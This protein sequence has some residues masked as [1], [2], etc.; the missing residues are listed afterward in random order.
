M[1][2]AVE[3][4]HELI[5]ARVRPG[6]A[7]IDATAGNGHDT[8]FLAKLTGPEGM[9]F[10]FDVQAGA[11]AGTLQ[12]LDTHGIPRHCRQVFHAGHET[13][14][15]AIPARWRGGI[16][17]VVFNLGYLP[18]SDKSVIT[19]AATTLAA[20]QAALT[21]LRPGGILVAVLYTGHAGGQEEADAVEAFA[22]ALPSRTFHSISWRT[23]NAARPAPL[24]VAIERKIS[25]GGN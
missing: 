23:L 6:D 10:A 14:S 3:F 16:A 4:S 8:L 12:L 17:A 20:M 11:V 22:A 7:V 19:T 5:T 1:P 25:T 9:V 24:V 15:E 13:M 2:R 21:M 18:A